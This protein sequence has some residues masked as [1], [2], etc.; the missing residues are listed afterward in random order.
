MIKYLIL[1]FVLVLFGCASES[2]RYYYCPYVVVKRDSAYLTQ[3]TNYS[4]DFQIEVKGFEGYCYYD[5]RVKKNKAVITPIF[6]IT[7]LR[8]ITETDIDFKYSTTTLKGPP[9]YLGSWTHSEN[10][11]IPVTEKQKDFNG[12]TIEM[13]IPNDNY[14]DFEILLGLVQ[15]P[16]EKIYNKKTFDI[17][18]KLVE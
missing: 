11:K 4:D 14:L 10:V 9:E 18:Y 15:S 1:F 8:A 16:N 6:N 7:K 2:S 17:D 5:D 12:K 13:T 3:K